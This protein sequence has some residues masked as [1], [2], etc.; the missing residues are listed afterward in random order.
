MDVHRVRE[1][2]PACQRMTYLNSGWS[3]P[4][5]T[6]VVQ[7]VEDRLE[8]ESYEGPTSPPVYQSGREIQK[9]ARN[10]AASLLNV[11][12][13]EITLTQCTTDGLNVVL[14]GLSW[15]E[16]DEVITFG[17][18]HSSVLVPA[19]FLQQRHGVRLKVLEL[20]PATRTKTFSAG[21][22]KP[23]LIAPGCSSLAIFSTRAAFKC[24]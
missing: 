9:G 13:D 14:N 1:Q 6:G 7:A 21:L 20:H 11:S 10:A 16:G 17:L 19:Y 15:S 18:E 23:S 8:Y 4:V 24:P 5:P 3:G 12:S 2:I 22:L